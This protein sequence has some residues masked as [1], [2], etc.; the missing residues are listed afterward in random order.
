M[1]SLSKRWAMQLCG[2]TLRRQLLALRLRTDG[3][4]FGAIQAEE[5]D[6]FQIE[7]RE[8]A[9]SGDVTDDA[10]QERKDHTGAFDQQ[11]GV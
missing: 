4:N 5:I 8:T 6:V 2:Q 3:A 11:L 7:R 1:Q 10:P 9:V